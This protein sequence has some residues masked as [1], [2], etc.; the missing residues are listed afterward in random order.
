MN[1]QVVMGTQE[2]LSHVLRFTSLFHPGRCVLVPCDRMGHVDID[3][4][5]DRLKLTYL[6]ARAMIG[7]EYAYPVVEAA[8]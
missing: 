3:S 5:G 8:H 1:G 2:G 7:R 4:L 6:G